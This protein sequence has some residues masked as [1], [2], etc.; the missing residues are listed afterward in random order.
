[1]P[2][3]GE[4]PIPSTHPPLPGWRSMVSFCR[5]WKMAQEREGMS[6]AHNPARLHVGWR[7]EQLASGSLSSSQHLCLKV[8]VS[9]S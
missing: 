8:C 1:M 9:L 7:W 3:L 2:S 4:G 5:V 6:V